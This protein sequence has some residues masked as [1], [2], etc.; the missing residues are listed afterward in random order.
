MH[1]RLSGTE[2]GLVAYWPFDECTGIKARDHVGNHDA[3]L[4]GGSW[5]QPGVKV[6]AYKDV[7]GCVDSLCT[8]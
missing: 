3:I 5:N 6:K 2:E 7:F 4:H 8:N 1:L